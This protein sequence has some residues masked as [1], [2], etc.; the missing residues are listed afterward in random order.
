M[1]KMAPCSLRRG[2]LV[3]LGVVL[4]AAGC[5]SVAS[6]SP[7][8]TTKTTDQFVAST[9]STTTTPATTTPAP[10]PA[11]LGTLLATDDFGIQLSPCGFG[12]VS[13][14]P[15][16]PDRRCTPGTVD[17]NVTQD[18]IHS[19]I[20]V[21][22]YTST[23]RPS[24]YVTGKEKIVSM[25]AYSASGSTGD[26]EYD[27]LVSLELGGSPNVA[28]N[29]FPE[30]YAGPYGARVKDRLENRLHDL[31]CSGQVSLATAQYQ[32]ATDWIGA[33]RQYVGPLS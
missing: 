20:C 21:S 25:R 24:S 28:A 12:V 26:Y 22:G 19:T 31:V 27:H 18:N 30:P 11:P 9:S 17:P 33:Y 16:L 32:E 10:A 13:G 29:L 5:S 6:S 1:M 14:W 15:A 2:V 8:N 23:V 4:L 7:P 3:L